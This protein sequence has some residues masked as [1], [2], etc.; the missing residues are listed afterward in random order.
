MNLVNAT[1]MPAWY[2]LGLERSGHE[3]IV[4][5][6]KGTFVIPI[7]GGDPHLAEE[8]SPL[9][10]SDEFSGE[11][12]LSAPVYESDFALHKPRCDVLFNGSAYAP[13]GRPVPRVPVSLS[14][15]SFTK[16]FA[17]V[18]DRVWQR[19]VMS[20]SAS[21]A[22]P[23]DVM[24][25]SYDR[26]FGGA[27]ASE[28]DPGQVHTYLT[29][30]VGVGFG[31]GRDSASLFGSPLPNTEE[32]GRSVTKPDGN[33]RPMAFGPIGR[34]WQPRAPLAGTYDQNW[35]D[36][37]FPFLP[38]DFDERYYQ[39]APA[40]QQIEY[41]TGGEEVIL[42][43]L[44]RH[45]RLRFRLPTLR[46]PIEFTDA[47]NAR[48]QVDATLDTIVFEPDAG[49]M[50]LT[51]RASLPLKRNLLERREVVV[52]RPSSGFYR[53][54]ET[55]K[56]YY[57]SLGQL[58]LAVREDNRGAELDDDTDAEEIAG[59]TGDD[60]ETAQPEHDDKEEPE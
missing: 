24:P 45:G 15:G 1:G 58:P 50:L 3:R 49:R 32:S 47:S 29:N 11:P 6:V 42:D 54:R 23:F 37:V 18:G 34:S 52:G 60:M 46:V 59:D 38:A 10:L 35:M 22:E 27:F 31:K 25:I 13:R 21:A 57:T 12:G 33:Y 36:N 14:L 43:N 5:A 19:S 20:V 7:K 39:A 44:S 41:P 4:V 30:P 56:P 28:K 2:T 8:Q 16:S 9:V 17:V 40:D 48:T 51:W 55:G 53:A 26:A